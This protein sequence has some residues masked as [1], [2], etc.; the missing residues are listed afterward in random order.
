[1]ENAIKVINNENGSAIVM[2]IIILA[3][4]TIVGISSSTTSTIELQIVRNQRIYQLNFYLAE[5]AV[6]EAAHRLNLLDGILDY[7]DLIPGTSS[8]VWLNDAATSLDFEDSVNWDN[9][10]TLPD[11]SAQALMGA[12]GECRFAIDYKGKQSGSSLKSGELSVNLYSLY[13][14]SQYNNGEMIIDIG[15]KKPV[16]NP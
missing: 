9:D 4:L 3:I 7:K 13:G 16:L 12:A 15:S 1:M 14:L 6:Y 8:L 5:S 11:N 2:A 10:G